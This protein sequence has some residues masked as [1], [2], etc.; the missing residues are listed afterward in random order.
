MT[1]ESGKQA[2][3]IQI[4]PNIS[5]SK[6]M[7]FGQLREYKGGETFFLKIQTQNGVMKLFLDLFPKNPN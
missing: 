1:S 7:K 3:A 2:I 5:R 4:L 6:E